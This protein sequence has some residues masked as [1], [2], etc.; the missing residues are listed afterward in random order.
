M[1]RVGEFLYKDGWFGIYVDS[2][3]VIR[4]VGPFD[5]QEAAKIARERKIML[6]K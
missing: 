6:D 5:T 1:T 3:G 4:R 2:K